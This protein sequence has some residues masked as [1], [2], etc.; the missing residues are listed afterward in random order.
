MT[1]EDLNNALQSAELTYVREVKQQDVPLRVNQEPLSISSAQ[2]NISI[3]TRSASSSKP[4]RTSRGDCPS[5]TGRRRSP[6]CC[7]GMLSCPLVHSTG[8]LVYVIHSNAAPARDRLC[9]SAHQ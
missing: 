3:G 2:R 4:V 9:L 7:S 8:T 1:P 5:V 6:S